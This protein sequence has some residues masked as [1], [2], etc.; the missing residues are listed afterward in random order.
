MRAERNRIIEE[1]RSLIATEQDRKTFDDL[2]NTAK[3]VFPYVENHLFY[4]EHW[5][6]SVFWGKIREVGAIMQEH[7]LIKEVEDIW[8]LRRDEIKQGLWDVVTAWATGVK[9]RGTAVWPP[10]IAWRKEV[11]QKFRDWS[12][13]PALGTAPE[14]IQEPFTI[15]LWGV[16][17][18]S[19]ADWSA[20]QEVHGSRE[21]Q[22][23]EGIRRQPRHCRGARSGLPQCLGDQ[24]AAGGG[25]SGFAHHLTVLGAGVCQDQ[26]LRHRCGR[27]HEPCSDRLP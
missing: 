23:I 18:S 9:P 4:V 11:M 27:H 12:A 24:G 22:R 7:G 5:F 20:V 26:G 16:T 6:H 14:V 2:L 25:D 10:E 3:T 15:V 21:H 19:L 1:Y 13:P 8:Y 17:N